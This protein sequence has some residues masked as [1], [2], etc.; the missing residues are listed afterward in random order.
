MSRVT[1]SRDEA[2]VESLLG[3][4][5]LHLAQRLVDVMD[6][7]EDAAEVFAQINVLAYELEHEGT[8]GQIRSEDFTKTIDLIA[9]AS[10]GGH[11]NAIGMLEEG[12][13]V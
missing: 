2:R 4:S 12:R 11:G 9:R 3:Y 5:N 7:L 13:P 1:T 6:A 10:V 8:N